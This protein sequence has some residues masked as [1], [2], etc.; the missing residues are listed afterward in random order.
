MEKQE[1]NAVMQAKTELNRVKL[2]Q[3]SHK[4][5]GIETTITTEISPLLSKAAQLK[6]EFDDV[7]NE[8]V[9]LD[10]EIKGVGFLKEVIEDAAC[11]E[12]VVE[13]ERELQAL[14]R[15]E[16]ERQAEF[17]SLV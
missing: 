8:I 14:L 17:A 4:A 5:S 3:D 12:R 10:R 9:H 6:S 16:G 2:A 15:L 1:Y 11:A 13:A 7:W